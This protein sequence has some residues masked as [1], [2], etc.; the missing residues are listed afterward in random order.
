MA[1]TV[2]PITPVTTET[3]LSISRRANASSV[4]AN[5]GPTGVVGA[6]R[7]AT[8]P[9]AQLMT[10][11]TTLETALVTISS[12]FGGWAGAIGVA[13]GVSVVI[14]RRATTVREPVVDSAD[15][16]AMPSAATSSA[17]RAVAADLAAVAD[18]AGADSVAVAGV[19]GGMVSGFDCD[20]PDGV[21]SGSGADGTSAA[22]V[23]AVSVGTVVSEAVSVSVAVSVSSA[24]VPVSCGV[25]AVLVL[26]DVP[27]VV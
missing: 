7:P 1:A 8:G 11:D 9:R 23:G 17:G 27:V 14:A 19:E 22:V 21:R 18:G 12:G 26:P 5:G 2:F 10:L 6:A 25:G 24:G 13:G 20:A 15:T 16:V 4:H 3:K